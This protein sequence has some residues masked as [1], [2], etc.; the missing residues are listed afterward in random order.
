MI[1]KFTILAVRRMSGVTSSGNTPYTRAAVIHD[2]LYWAQPCTREQSDNL[3]MIA[4]KES[5]VSWFRRTS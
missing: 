1:P 5:G 3:L 2:Y 4:M